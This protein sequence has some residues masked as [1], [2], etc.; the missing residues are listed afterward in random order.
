MLNEDSKTLALV[1]LLGLMVAGVMLY[2]FH[3]SAR[4][5]GAVPQEDYCVSQGWE[6]IVV[7]VGGVDRTILYKG[8]SGPWTNGAIVAMHGGSGSYYNFCYPSGIGGTTAMTNFANLAVAS[9][10]AVLSLD[11]TNGTVT[12]NEGR[13]CG[14]VWD[15][16]VR[17]RPN[18]DLS[19]IEHVITSVT[20]SRRPVG[21]AGDVFI[22]G[23]SSGGFMA[24]RASTRH[25]NLVNA[26]APVS[27]GDPYGWHRICDPALGSHGFGDNIVYGRGY[28]NETDLQLVQVN[29]CLTSPPGAYPNEKPWETSNPAS[30]PA[31][32]HFHDEDDGVADISC[33]AKAAV[34][35]AS[36]GYPDDGAYIIPGE[37]TR[38]LDEHYW[39]D[40]YNQPVIDFFVSHVGSAPAAT[41]TP[42]S[43][44]GRSHSPTFIEEPP[45]SRPN[46]VAVGGAAAVALLLAACT[47]LLWK[48]LRVTRFD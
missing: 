3:A 44:G 20:P 19:F 27:A 45:A 17:A 15:D 2:L 30:K 43:V 34:Q 14:K 6:R 36:Y 24:V 39:Q 35:L 5:V 11:S 28:D 31:F 8:P 22:A 41:P 29:A 4:T 38:T 32:K 40:V 47:L 18:L 16:E 1:F 26:F 48:H 46:A 10:F 33:Q 13:V 42:A 12:D 9:G 25:D 7:N 23:I 21:S 37:G